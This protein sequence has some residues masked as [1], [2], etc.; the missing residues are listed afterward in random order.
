MRGYAPSDVP[1]DASYQ[2]GALALDAVALHEALGGDGDAVL[3]GH[4]WGAVITHI[5]ANVRPDAF[6]KVVTMAVPPGNAVGVAFLSNLA[7][8]KRSWYM[9]FFQHPFADFVV[10]ANDLAYIDML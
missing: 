2:T 3:I 9:F 8:I 6:A 7:Q 5:A 10:G 1:A 4:D